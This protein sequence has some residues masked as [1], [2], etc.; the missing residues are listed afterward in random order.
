MTDDEKIAA[1]YSQIDHLLDIEEHW[2]E[3]L[4][5]VR[6]ARDLVI[7]PCKET[8]KRFPDATFPTCTGHLF[9]EVCKL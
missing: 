4:G 3:L 2:Y 1:S 7:C 6:D 9:N 8:L 5:D